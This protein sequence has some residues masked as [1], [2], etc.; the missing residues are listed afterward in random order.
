M[1]YDC[2]YCKFEAVDS[3]EEP[4]LECKPDDF[5][6]PSHFVALNSNAVN[7][8][9]HYNHGNYECIDV[10]VEN[11]GKEAVQHFCLLNAFKYVWRTNYKNGVEDVKKA[12]FYLDYYL[13]L[14][15]EANE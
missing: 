1:N 10:M 13:K 2:K 8:P 7:H 12:Q 6:V 14:E 3:Y 5:G 15:G 4:C 11:F 9:S